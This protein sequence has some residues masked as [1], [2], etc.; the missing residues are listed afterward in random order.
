MAPRYHQAMQ[1]RML[2]RTMSILMRPSEEARGKKARCYSSTM[3]QVGTVLSSQFPSLDAMQ[4]KLGERHESLDSY[5]QKSLVLVPQARATATNIKTKE[6]H[7]TLLPIAQPLE[8]SASAQQ[9]RAYILK[10]RKFPFCL[11]ELHCN[12]LS[13][14]PPIP[15]LLFL[16]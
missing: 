13:H 12:R 14:Q 8:S 4:K 7:S 5:T 11:V 1:P 10:E 2:N 9:P 3:Q 16:P 15:I 6:R